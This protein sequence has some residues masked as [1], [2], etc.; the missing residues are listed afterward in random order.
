MKV[1][2]TILM[3]P[4][5]I[6]GVICGLFVVTVFKGIEYVDKHFDIT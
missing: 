3:A 4:F 1:I 5:F 2:K 6:I